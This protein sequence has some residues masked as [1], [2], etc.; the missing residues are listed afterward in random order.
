ME[1][2]YFRL[3]KAIQEEGSLAN[4]SERLF[5]T[6]SAL[7]HQLRDLEE[8]LG[9]KVFYRSRNKWELTDEGAELY[10]LANK[11]FN[12]IDESFSKIKNIKEGSKGTIKLSAE[13][14]SFFHAI[15]PFIQKMGILYP[16]IDIEVTLGATHQTISQVLSNEID[17]AIVTSKPVSEEL[18]V[19]P[20]FKDEIFA[21]MH[22]ENPLS[23]LEFLEANH[24]LNEHLFINSF[25]LEGVAVYEHFL[26]PNKINP[27]KI[28][29][30]PFTE[31][32]LSMIQAN[33][34]LMCAPKWQLNPFKLSKELAFKRIS[35]NG[36]KRTHYLVVKMEHRNKK[37]INDFICSFEEDFLD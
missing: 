22:K 9:F 25:P 36:L 16:E 27:K 23:H 37:Y 28:S 24:F 19:S 8:R 20:V 11:L 35:K 14:Q 33:M 18:S 6:Q 3:I 29:A 4:S 15:P 1:L 10:S 34:G 13:C 7:S 5:L 12:S 26:K 32:S 17:I 30:I 31:I 21:I 2:K